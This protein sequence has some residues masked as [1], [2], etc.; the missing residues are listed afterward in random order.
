MPEF[1][2]ATLTA[3]F[4]LKDLESARQSGD[5]FPFL[6]E[7]PETFFGTMCC[8]MPRWTSIGRTGD[9]CYA[10]CLRRLCKIPVRLKRW[11]RIY[12]ASF[13]RTNLHVE[14]YGADVWWH[15]ITDRYVPDDPGLPGKKGQAPESIGPGIDPEPRP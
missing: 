14:Q 5:L 12:A 10:E 1:D 13:A 7:V 4:L 8:L 3:D 15:D 2:L 6:E 11:S 9:L